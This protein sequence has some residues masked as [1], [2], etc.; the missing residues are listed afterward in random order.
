MT[1]PDLSN[2]PPLLKRLIEQE[3]GIKQAA[4]KLGMHNN[5]V[6][7]ISSGRREMSAPLQEKLAAMFGGKADAPR[8]VT[9]ADAEPPVFVSPIKPSRKPVDPWDGKKVNIKVPLKEGKF[10][11]LKNVPEPLA[12]LIMLHGG[13]RSEAGRSMGYNGAGS[14]GGV[15]E[16]TVK[17]SP[18]LHAKVT[19]ALNGEAPPSK[20]DSGDDFDKYTLGLAICIVQLNKYE[21]LELVA[22]VLNGLLV[23]RKSTKV[24]YI[25]IYKLDKT[26]LQAFKKL[27][28][29]DADS[30][31]CP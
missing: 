10:K 31:V 27:G 20:D 9:G 11:T 2:A 22:E 29:R 24:G 4:T 25:V 17:Y 28:R 13:N 7:K 6:G 14:I 23:F 18:N 19:A 26:K 5:Y 3:G 21:G 30:I 8:V 12:K 1:I 15:I 16:G